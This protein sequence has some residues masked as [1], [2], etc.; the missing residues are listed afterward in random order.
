MK[1][2]RK[3]LAVLLVVVNLC[4]CSSASQPTPVVESNA[5]AVEAAVVEP[6]VKT[7]E[8]DA[9]RTVEVPTQITKVA[10]SGSMA[11][12][13][14]LA[15]APDTMVGLTSNWDDTAS[16][17]LDPAYFELPILGQFYGSSAE[18]N[19]EELLAQ[20]PQ[21]IVDVGEYKD[22]LAADLDDLQAK[23]GIPVV[24]ISAEL[25]TYDRAFELL[26]FVLG[27]EEEAAVLSEYCSRVYDDTM[28]MMEAIGADKKDVVFCTGT[29]GTN[30]IA[31]GSYQAGLLDV[32]GN[33]IAV[34]E[35]PT[36]KGTGDAV[37]F[38]QL[39]LWD[40]EVI[41]FN[42]GSAYETVADDPV[43]QELQAIQTGSYYEAPYGPYNW[44]GNP[45]SVQQILGMLWYG[46]LLYPD[47]FTGDF[48]AQVNEY[49]ALFYHCTLSQEQLDGLLA[50]SIG[51]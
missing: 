38:E 23:T 45:P 48:L 47:A 36:S 39:L 33:N 20:E 26:G 31:Q 46:A 9:G 2:V 5:V 17:Y 19:Y 22:D 41:I 18:F 49:Y 13:M 44:T 21:V 8:D 43:W 7:V 27:R 14:L 35:S 28:A 1:Y 11:Q 34:V 29:E 50:H 40:P 24:H 6:T 32:M 25:S 3:A 30:V 37:D 15:L 12:M 10:V 16:Q 51:A 42:Y 4:A